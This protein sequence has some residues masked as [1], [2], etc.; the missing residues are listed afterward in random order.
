MKPATKANKELNNLT[1]NTYFES[2]PVQQVSNILTQ[3]GFKGLEDG[4]YCGREGRLN[5]QIGPK[6]WIAMT[7]Y[8]LGSGRY[9]IVAYVS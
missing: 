8:K 7:W 1:R 3:N 9:E 4:I 5:E 6:N 2:I